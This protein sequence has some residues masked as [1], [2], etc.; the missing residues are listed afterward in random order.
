M[1][2]QSSTEEIIGESTKKDRII[3]AYRVAP[4]VDKKAAADA[5]DVSYEYIRQIFKDISDRQPERWQKLR[6]GDLDQDFSQELLDA[7]ETRLKG[8][9]G[10]AYE[11]HQE[12]EEP[13]RPVRDQEQTDEVPTDASGNIAAEN[14]LAARE[15]LALLLEQAQ[16]TENADAE[17][18][19]KKGIELLD[20]LLEASE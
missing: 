12:T 15:Q 5:L 11:G 6:E 2:A 1:S 19:A 14:V 4:D 16:Y 20:E 8:I 9:E 13:K 17:F 10:A 7:V 3:A 18:V